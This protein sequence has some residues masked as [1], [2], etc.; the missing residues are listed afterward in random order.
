MPNV[1]ELHKRLRL[2]VAGHA[3]HENARERLGEAIRGA[4][5]EVSRLHFYAY[6]FDPPVTWAGRETGMSHTL[7]APFV[8]DEMSRSTLS[9]DLED[10]APE[11]ERASY[12]RCIDEAIRDFGEGKPFRMPLRYLRREQLHRHWASLSVLGPV[13][14]GRQSPLLL[15][16]WREDRTFREGAFAERPYRA[17]D[18]V[19]DLEQKIT[20]PLLQDAHKIAYTNLF[21][22]LYQSLLSSTNPEDCLYF[23]SVPLC[24]SRTFHG[25]IVA[26]AEVPFGASV[27]LEKVR[28]PLERVRAALREAARNTYM[29]TLILSQ[30]SWEEHVLSEFHR[31]SSGGFDEAL[32]RF[33]ER[34][35]RVY[36]LL[37]E[38]EEER[39]LPD[40]ADE[41][42]LLEQSLIEL[43]DRRWRAAVSHPRAIPDSLIFRKMMAAS[44]GLIGVIRRVAELALVEPESAPLQA[45]LVV[46]PPGSGKEMV[47]KLIPLLSRP[48]WDKPVVTLNMGSV[49]LDVHGAEGGFRGLLRTLRDGAL[50]EGGT[51]V[52][53]E[54]NSLDIAAQPMLLRL[55]EQGEISPLEA[56]GGGGSERVV[57][58]LVL[59]LVNEEPARLTLESLRE[60]MAD[61]ELFGELLG[62]ALYEHW[63]GKSRLRDDLYYRIRR[64]G[65]IRMTGL[66]SRRQDVP[67]VF[68]FLLRQL[69][70]SGREAVEIFLTCEAMIYLTDK[71]LDWRGNM[72]KLEAVARQV[73]KNIGRERRREELVRVD[74]QDVRKALLDVGMVIQGVP[75]AE[76]GPPVHP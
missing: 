13:E 9:L 73:R 56:A 5:L 58:W 68:Y 65:E 55:L 47:S 33:R 62:S 66:N 17:V 71:S 11:E 67:I 43:W 29:P 26:M 28:A 59:G 54:L 69:F 24:T 52:L 70:R 76:E 36:G 75:A 35:D 18:C 64:C 60:R 32:Q 40:G 30:N 63:K 48:F 1:D 21:S 31:T 38:S 22:L 53:D 25:V 2:R 41:N 42:D 4:G 8:D 27:P 10:D 15:G 50:K 57:P 72:R 34:P 16:K 23:A 3:C 12:V 61:T 49:L 14:A 6:F 19:E 7:L 39:E 20:S 51:L 37:A 46:A 74:V 44:P 45:V